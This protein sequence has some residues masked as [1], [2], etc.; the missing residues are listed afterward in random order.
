MAM[1]V[2]TRLIPPEK[3]EEWRATLAAFGGPRREE[4]TA[5]RTR[6]GV[7]RQGVFV[8]HTSDGPME[9]MV[10]EADDPGRALEM[11]ATSEEPFDVEFRAYLLNTLGLDLSQPPAGPPPEQVLDWTAPA[12]SH[13]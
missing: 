5:A 8:E 11:I 4:Y 2:L 7:T 9:I 3:Y 13:A 1:M 6:Q 10:M 12:R